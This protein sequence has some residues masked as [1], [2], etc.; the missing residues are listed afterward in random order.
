[1]KRLIST[2]T[3]LSL[4]ISACADSLENY[5]KDTESIWR[6]GS[7]AEDGTFTAISLSMLGW[8]LGLAVGIGILASVLHQS[9][10]TTHSHC[11]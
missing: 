2:L 6:T 9:T 1:M 5:K 8:G 3:L 4:S 11:D 10:A 7:G